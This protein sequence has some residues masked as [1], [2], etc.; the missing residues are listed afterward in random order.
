MHTKH[1]FIAT[2]SLV[3]WHIMTLIDEMV[4][5]SSIYCLAITSLDGLM[6]Y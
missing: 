4:D 3:D 5:I 2:F 1:L 6:T